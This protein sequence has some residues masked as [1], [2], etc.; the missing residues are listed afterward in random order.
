MFPG[1][2]P[3]SK[4]I[5]FD[6]WAQYESVTVDRINEGF[7]VVNVPQPFTYVTPG[8]NHKDIINEQYVFDHWKPYIFNLDVAA[9]KR[10]ALDGEPLLLGA[11]G[12]MWGDEHY[13]GIEESDL[14]Y[15]LEKSLAMI[16]FKT[17]NDKSQ[18]T[19]LDYQKAFE[20]TRLR[21]NYLPYETKSSLVL[22]LDAAYASDKQLPDL[23][24]NGLTIRSE[25]RTEVVDLDGDKWFKFDGTNHL[26]TE[27]ET[28]G[29]PY[30]LELTF[31][32]TNVDKGSLLLSEDGALFL[33]GKGRNQ[34]GDVLEGFGLNRYFYSQYLAPKLE[35]GKDYKLTLTGTREVLNVYLNDE[36][37]ASLTHV[38]GSNLGTRGNFRTSF[39]LPIKTIGKGFE[40]YIKDLKVY[41]RTQEAAE[42]G[43]E[44]LERINIALHKPVYDYRHQSDFWNQ[45]IKPY[46]KGRLT[47]GDVDGAEGRWNSSNHDRDYFIVDLEKMQDFNA[48]QVIFDNARPATAFKVLI[49]DDLVTFREVK[50]VADNSRAD[51]TLD[52]GAVKARYVKF[53]SVARKQGTNEVAVKEFR[54]YQTQAVDKS[55]LAQQFAKKEVN[56]EQEDWLTI[57]SVLANKFATAQEVE[58]A[59]SLVGRLADQGSSKPDSETTKNPQPDPVLRRDVVTL[60]VAPEQILDVNL[61]VGEVLTLREGRPGRLVKVYADTLIDGQTL[62]K[63]VEIEEIV[64]PTSKIVRVGTRPVS[65]KTTRSVVEPLDFLVERIPVAHLEDGREVVVR[66]GVAGRL[67]KVYE[68][69]TTAGQ[70]TSRLIELKNRVEPISRLVLVGTAPKLMTQTIRREVVTDWP[71]ELER[72]EIASLPLGEEQVLRQGRAGRTVTVYEDTY[73]NGSKTSERILEI[74][75]LVVPVKTLVLVGTRPIVTSHT[76]RREVVETLPMTVERVATTALKP[77][78]ERILR[79]GRAGQVIKVYEDTYTNGIKTGERV[80]AVTSVVTPIRQLILVGSLPAEPARQ[81]LPSPSPAQ[82][83]RVVESKSKLDLAATPLA[84]SGAG[85]LA[86]LGVAGLNKEE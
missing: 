8:R 38:E 7:K 18:R 21:N 34:A 47:D 72:V 22:N 5:I 51:V 74:K 12:A 57:R 48:V 31:K 46:H 66:E 41:N 14:Y 62:S 36:R 61:D 20:A 78:E 6:E 19:Y 9:D 39:N 45:H 26:E 33:N 40:G 80:L 79:P 55:L 35:V 83:S 67:T 44:N 76:Q 71:I 84:M 28:L 81:P 32:P 1:K 82:R 37:V 11:K 13:E 50:A 86:T 53:E 4:D 54:V 73:T 64:L 70:T 23:S 25:G 75:N 17:W 3:V 60:T 2:T 85:L 56:P 24:A 69:L 59:L 65:T 29:L 16:G 30:T 27:L 63:L 77:G 68:D 52:L 42:I 15:R 58:K 10:Q 49:S 43:K